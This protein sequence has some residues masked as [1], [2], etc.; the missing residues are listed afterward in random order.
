MLLINSAVPKV[1]CAGADLKERA[2]MPPDAVA[3]F[4]RDLRSAFT[5]LEQLPIPTIACID[6]FA[7]GGGLEMA[8]AADLRIAGS[9]AKLGLVETKLA[10]I[11]GFV[12][13]D[14]VLEELR[15][16]HA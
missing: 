3:Q 14:K 15:D 6:G 11:P 8:L 4:V 7:L 2:V 1:F 12:F 9:D 16:S 5:D 13:F 10:I